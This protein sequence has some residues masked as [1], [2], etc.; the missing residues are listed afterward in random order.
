MPFTPAHPALI[1]PFLKIN[2]RFVSPSGFV[3][4]SMSPDFEYFF[5]MSVNGTYSH[6]FWGLFYFNLPVSFVVAMLFHQLVKGNLIINLPGFFQRRY[7]ALLKF[8]FLE[9]FK[10]YSGG[11]LVCCWIGAA[12]HIFWD[13]FT[14]NN[15]YF[16]QEL[17]IYK[18]VNVNFLGARYP[19][20]YVLQHFSTLAGMAAI[21]L[22]ILYMRVAWTPVIYRPSVLYW[23]V[24]ILMTLSVVFLRFIILPSDL[25]LGNFV[26][27]SI[28][29][30]CLA[31]ILTGF[32][33]KRSTFNPDPWQRNKH[34]GRR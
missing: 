13:S 23:S 12:S 29:G 34:S 33:K 27:S 2:W 25:N 3:I 10:K 11:F 28:S 24:I 8:D 5:K 16:V 26:V 9:Y 18:I 21:A 19:L 1:L 31:L 30:F 14:H 20:F 7:H 4:G 17:P 15:G 6:T 32:L 22:Y